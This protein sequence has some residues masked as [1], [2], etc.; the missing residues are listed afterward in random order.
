MLGPHHIDRRHCNCISPIRDAPQSDRVPCLR[1]K[2]REASGIHC[3]FSIAFRFA[4]ETKE[5]EGGK[6]HLQVAQHVCSGGAPAP[7]GRG[8]CDDGPLGQGLHPPAAGESAYCHR[9]VLPGPALVA[10]GGGALRAAQHADHAGHR[11]HH[12]NGDHRLAEPPPALRAGLPGPDSGHDPR[13]R[14]S[15]RRGAHCK[16]A[17]R[18]RAVPNQVR[19]QISDL[20]EGQL[21]T[22]QI[23]FLTRLGACR[24][25]IEQHIK[26]LPSV[27]KRVVAGIK[28]VER[29]AS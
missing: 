7:A 8:E 10:A 18:W 9:Q 4:A 19:W 15:A 5:V 24:R 12:A 2:W 1:H 3:G 29:Q 20:S 16:A 25:C 26:M 22:G 13:R 14:V 21:G 17:E 6:Q 27:E 11:A 28:E 23:G